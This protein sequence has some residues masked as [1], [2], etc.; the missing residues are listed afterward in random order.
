MKLNYCTVTSETIEI[1]GSFPNLQKLTG[2]RLK[3]GDFDPEVLGSIMQSLKKLRKLKIDIDPCYLPALYG[4]H[5]SLLKLKIECDQGNIN[6]E[7]LGMLGAHKPIGF[8]LR[9]HWN[10]CIYK[11]EDMIRIIEQSPTVIF[12]L[13]SRFEE[14]SLL[15]F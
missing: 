1:I 11:Y 14:Q 3:Q 15:T 12:Y 7:I 13:R 5:P 2:L 10:K 9:V 4:H 8:R 6:T